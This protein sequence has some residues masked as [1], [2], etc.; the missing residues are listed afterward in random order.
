MVDQYIFVFITGYVLGV[1]STL[2]FKRKGLNV[3]S[4]VALLII[5]IWLGQHSYGFLFDKEVSLLMDFAGFGAAGNF[6]GIKFQDL[7]SYVVKIGKKR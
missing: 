7:T 1:V 5:T 3:E 2:F 4:S 6:V